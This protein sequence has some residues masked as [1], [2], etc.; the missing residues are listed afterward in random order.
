MQAATELL[1]RVQSSAESGKR[2][3]HLLEARLLRALLLHAQGRENEALM[4]LQAALVTAEP[5]GF[6][7]IFMNLGPIMAHL[8]ERAADV[9]SPTQDYA[10]QLARLAQ[11]EVADSRQVAKGKQGE[12]EPFAH[13]APREY[14]SPL[15]DPLSD[16][17]LAVMRLIAD[18]LS[19]QEIAARLT[20]TVGTVKAHINRI[21]S[22]LAVTNRVQAIKRASELDL[23]R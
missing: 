18:G 20:L 21:Y 6:V 19:N 13:R 4:R 15:L 3:F 2:G 22:K 9:V 11:A 14:P 1:D 5:E 8:L 23:L 16:R 7:R 12:P 17:E 10:R